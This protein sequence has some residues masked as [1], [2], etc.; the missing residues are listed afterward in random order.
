M[1]IEVYVFDLDGTIVNSGEDIAFAVNAALKEFSYWPVPEKEIISL[2]Q[3][4]SEKM[5]LNVLNRSTKNHFSLE[6]DYNQKQFKKICEFYIDFYQ[7]HPVIKTNLYAGIK[8]LLKV[9]KEKKKTIVLFTSKEEAATL[10]ILENL[11][12]ADYFDF[13]FSKD[14][15]NLGLDSLLDCINKKKSSNY[16][17]KNCIIF[18]DT[19]LDIKRGRAFGATTVA[20]RGG[21]G[22]SAELLAENPDFSFSVASEI[23]KFIDALSME[24]NSSKIIEFAM[25]NEVPIIQDEGSNFILD[26][27]KSHNVK[28]VLEIGTAIG[29]SAIRFAQVSP[30]MRVTSIEIDEERY[31]TAQANVQEKG[32]ESRVKIIF[33]DALE[34]E[35]NDFF[36]LI[37]IDAAKAQYQKFFEKYKHNLN[38]GG[39][40]I[41]DNLSFHGMV[42]DLSLTHNYS[43]KKLV[44]K[45]R[46]FIDFLKTNSEFITDFYSKGDGISV[47]KRKK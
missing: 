42:E 11:D 8:N 44:K 5:L 25:K 17:S 7:N 41:C 6:T 45:I 23:E 24:E 38:E 40:I 2:I 21:L 18:G 12:I 13:I 4:D 26:Y 34:Y 9:L 46:K 14:S 31:K 39:V 36:D 47:S 27:I 37:F 10:K 43:T 1:A 22:N 28:S 35:L 20:C 19:A 15:F 29:Y 33:A 32:L 3:D 16:E 30:E